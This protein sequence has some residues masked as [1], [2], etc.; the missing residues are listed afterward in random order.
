MLTPID[1]VV[2][3]GTSVTLVI[4][5]I[6]LHD[7]EVFCL[8]FCLTKAEWVKFRTA[9]KTEQVY[10]QNGVGGIVYPLVTKFADIFFADRLRKCWEYRIG[11]GNNG[12][13]AAI[14]HFIAFN[15]P[16]CACPIDPA[17]APVEASEG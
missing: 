4:P 12:M 13:P 14:A 5:E 15:P 2:V 16:D 7:E 9:T 11:Y 1:I 8:K 10:I 17:N 3:P 6:F